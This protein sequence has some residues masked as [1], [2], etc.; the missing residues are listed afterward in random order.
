MK[1]YLMLSI[2]ITMLVG[3]H[4]QTPDCPTCNCTLCNLHGSFFLSDKCGIYSGANTGRV[5]ASL[6]AFEEDDLLQPRLDEFNGC[7]GAVVTHSYVA[8]GEDGMEQALIDDVG[9]S[10]VGAGGAVTT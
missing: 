7:T 3:I 8:E 6:L 1:L 2:A 4:A 9:M 5:P 10:Y